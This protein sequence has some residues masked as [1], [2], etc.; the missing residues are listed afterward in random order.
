[1]KDNRL[2]GLA[3]ILGTVANI[4]TMAL[5]P[6]GH[7]LLNGGAGFQFQA[8]LARSV[9]ALALVA[10]AIVFLGALALSRHLD[11]RDRLSTVALVVYGMAM[12][13]GMMAVV[14]SGFLGP[15]LAKHL[16]DASDP[17]KRAFEILF[18]YNFAIN[19]AFA[20]ILA[21][22][23]SM[24][25]VLWSIS[26]I[27]TRALSRAIGLYGILAGTLIFSIAA[28]GFL[29]LDVHGFGMV[30]LLQAVWFIT[31]GILLRKAPPVTT[32]P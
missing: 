10:M 27:K 15:G 22:A 4:I 2:G 18:A 5:H 13:A 31:V 1:M 17:D 14:F 30:V 26:I 23:S 29:R 32:E 28:P 9:H 8:M 19:Q 7:A 3:L 21:S 12:I 16:V 11:F 24:S 20:R 6:T 25:I